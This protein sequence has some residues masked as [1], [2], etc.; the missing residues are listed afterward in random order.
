MCRNCNG[1]DH[2]KNGE[3]ELNEQQAIEQLQH[4]LRDQLGTLTFRT[5]WTDGRGDGIVIA[6]INGQQVDHFIFYEEDDD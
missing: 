2:F 4:D 6:E 5:E 3:S 1:V